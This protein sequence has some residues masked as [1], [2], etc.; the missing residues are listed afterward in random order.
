MT[1][2]QFYLLIPV[3]LIS[4]VV[5]S[6]EIPTPAE[7]LNFRQVSSYPELSA[8]IKQ[9]DRQSD[10]VS[11]EKI[12]VSVKGLELN[13][14]LFST[15]DFGKDA[16]K[17][18][19]LI[20]AQQHGNEQSGKEGALLLARELIK[21][22]YRYLFDRIDFALIPQVNPDGSEMNKRRNANDADLNR[23]H[24]ILTEP[25]TKA[26]HQFF[27][28]Y[29]FEVTMDVHEYSPYGE[30][31]VTAGFRKNSDITL[32]I[33]T[34]LNVSEELRK[35]SENIALQYLF[36]F[37]SKRNFSCFTYCPGDPPGK[38][39]I[40]HSTF[41]IN[42]GRQ[43]FAIQNTLSFIQEGMN[44]VDNFTENL[45][46]RANGQMTGMKGLL[47]FVHKR[48]RSILKLVAEERQK[49]LSSTPNE[50]ISIQDEHSSN[51][52]TL[53]LPVFSYK[54]GKDSLVIISDYRPVVR[55]VTSVE[56]PLGYLIPESLTELLSWA[57]RQC[58]ESNPYVVRPEDRIEQYTI[59]DI[60]S[61]DFEG[62]TI[63]DPVVQTGNLNQDQLKNRYIY[64][65]TNQPKGN[66]IVLAL[67][68]KSMLGLVTYDKFRQLLKAGE[69]FPVLRLT[70][71]KPIKNQSHA[72]R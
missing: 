63:P 40:R 54:S 67:E 8:F 57:G 71:N 9:I 31:W 41:D 27:D 52:N 21:P 64:I 37:L 1:L 45:E 38:G 20:F 66:L 12:G 48:R 39:Y 44:G 49:L 34:N 18:K 6:Q 53:Q 51:G 25:E 2:K 5:F 28:K 69:S 60:N 68:P 61:I 47:E 24:L 55:S 50:R 36:S 43:S 46:M 72:N 22:E 16:G 30:D 11:I 59:L 58:L 14:L 42:D 3:I 56:K 10:L 62:D 7:K 23:N 33:S 26:L 32:G 17:I 13:A 29:H 65:P 19:V 4:F 35:F 70:N 15:T